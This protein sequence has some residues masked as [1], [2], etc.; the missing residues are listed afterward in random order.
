MRMRIPAW[1]AAVLVLYA[2]FT[3][4]AALATP[5]DYCA[6]YAKDFA[7]VGPAD[8]SRWQQQFENA[9][10]DCLFQYLTPQQES[11]AVAPVVKKTIKK[12]KAPKPKIVVEPVVI[13]QP[14]K[15]VADKAAAPV[16]EKKSTPLRERPQPGTPAWVDYCVNKYVSFNKEKGTYLSK[17]GVERKCLVTNN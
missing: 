7:N 17:T 16:L 4:D 3:A 9:Q 1:F 15:Q 13:E 12:R 6:A 5:E 8:K 10:K 14:Q 2:G 11:V